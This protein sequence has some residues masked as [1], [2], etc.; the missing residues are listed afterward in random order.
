MGVGSRRT[1]FSTA[2]RFGRGVVGAPVETGYG[3]RLR[4]MVIGFA[5]FAS[6]VWKIRKPITVRWMMRDNPH[7][8]AI[9]AIFNAFRAGI[10][11][12]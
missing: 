9:P 6:F 7:H 4:S 10:P 12:P 5:C 11:T 3:S 1:G 8:L 2:E